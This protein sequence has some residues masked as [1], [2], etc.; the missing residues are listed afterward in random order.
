MNVYD[1]YPSETSKYLKLT[2]PYCKGCGLDIASQGSPV[3]PWAWQLDLPPA[4]FDHYNAGHA[5]RGP[6][7][8]RGRAESLPVETGSLDF[9]YSSHLMEDFPQEKWPEIMGEWSRVL[10]SGGYLIILVPERTRWAAA[11][12]RGQSPN[13]SHSGPEPVE[14]DM[15]KAA[16]KIGLK[17]I[18]DK[19][20]DLWP[21]D[22]SILGVFQKP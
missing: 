3:V 16:E 6:I 12:A 21:E 15:T 2:T 19:M 18:I 1:N 7:Q 10:K 11:L 14:G 13:C 22:Y 5:P 9:V 17:V 4:E 20:T 8:L